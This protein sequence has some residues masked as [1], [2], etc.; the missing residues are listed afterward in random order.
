M[1]KLGGYKAIV[2]EDHKGLVIIYKST[3]NFRFLFWTELYND[4]QFAKKSPR[5]AL[6]FNIN[7]YKFCAT[8]LEIGERWISRSGSLKS[9]DEIQKILK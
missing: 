2:K 8:H 6:Y 3:L 4:K 1:F 5:F 9:I 7:G